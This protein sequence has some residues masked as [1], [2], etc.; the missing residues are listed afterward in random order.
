VG[1]HHAGRRRGGDRGH[2]RRV[3]PA[4]AGRY[5]ASFAWRF[6]RRPQLD[7]LIRRLMH[8]AVLT[9]PLLYHQLIAS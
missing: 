1:E 3:S 8:S 6:N 2:L 4:H 9:A 5:L 7:G